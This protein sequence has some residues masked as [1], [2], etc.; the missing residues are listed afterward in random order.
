MLKIDLQIDNSTI[1]QQ[2]SIKCEI[3]LYFLIYS[4]REGERERK[5]ERICIC[6]YI[7]PNY[8]REGCFFFFERVTSSR[9]EGNK[10]VEPVKLVLALEP[11]GS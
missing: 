2:T 7:L 11:S 10:I 5:I 6:I 3:F 9:K 8:A 4:Q 1:E